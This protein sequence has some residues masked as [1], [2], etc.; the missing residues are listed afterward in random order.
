MYDP[1]ADAWMLIDAAGRKML[2]LEYPAAH[3]KR[4]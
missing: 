4:W 3:P 1:D 2:F